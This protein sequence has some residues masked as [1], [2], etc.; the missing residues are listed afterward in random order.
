MSGPT[1]I[2]F[3]ARVRV[4]LSI[5]LLLIFIPAL[6]LTIRASLN[7]QRVEKD[8]V[9]EATVALAKLCVA[10][11]QTF[12]EKAKQLL[13]T[14]SPIPFLTLSSDPVGAGVHFGNLCKL[15]PEYC[16]FG[17][18]QTNGVLFA[19]SSAGN[20]RSHLTNWSCYER[21]FFT[22]QFSI[23]SVETNGPFGTAS[24]DLGYPILDAHGS[25]T[26]ILY[27]SL[28]LDE[29]QKVTEN[30]Q[31]PPETTLMLYDRTGVVL[32]RVPR[33]KL[34]RPD[35]RDS[36]FP[37]LMLQRDGVF[38]K[39]DADGVRKL[40]AL[41]S[42][43]DASD[44]ALVVSV[45]VP[46]QTS[47]AAADYVLWK[48]IA[49]LCCVFVVVLVAAYFYSERFLLRPLN[50]LMQSA[51]RL[52]ENQWQPANKALILNNGELGE[53]ARTFEQMA[54]TLEERRK[55]IQSSH[56]EV[57]QLNADLEKRVQ[58]RTAELAA[59]N[60][61]LEKFSYT[62]SHDLRAPL[63]AMQSF[64][65]ILK[66]DF[67]SQLSPEG[68]DFLERIERA[69]LRLDRLTT[70]ILCY[71]QVSAKQLPLEAVNLNALLADV[72]CTYPNFAAAELEVGPLL[73][74]MGQKSYLTQCFSNLIAN[75][76][77]FVAP[78]RKPH[79]KIWSENK[80]GVV[81]IWIEDNGIGM[82]ADHQTRI[83]EMFERLD[84]QQGFEG[85]GIGLAIVRAAVDRMRGDVGFESEVGK[86]SRFWIE[87]T[88]ADEKA[89]KAGLK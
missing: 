61:E 68:M 49:A 39:Q 70:D 13:I 34:I 29:L 8:K 27:A 22:K 21:A 47:F 20:T 32:A 12:V 11:H 74:V 46:S 17:L 25:V 24:L 35:R 86:G 45:A 82:A 89:A 5:L 43:S 6:L 33:E 65:S 77:K 41:A 79:V 59:A 31:L 57:R 72:L 28:K 42:L 1:N 4:Q 3:F 60:R 50:A 81:R 73:P 69:A 37:E 84:P 26:R 76:I 38:E 7:Q 67:S 51:R 64:A 66:E 14:V 16:D 62:V 44:T 56:E 15:M 19:A 63:R 9:R 54:N 71:S 78:N 85:T 87:L 52:A 80:N 2:P 48:N 55:E 30:I 10:K 18:L 75:A 23:G 83:F 53:L 40:F 36:S 88:S 58:E